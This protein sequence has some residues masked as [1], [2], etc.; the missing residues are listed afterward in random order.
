MSV[1]FRII[2]SAEINQAINEIYSTYGDEVS[3]A[4]KA[5]TLL[6]F[7]K[8]LDLDTGG[9]ETVWEVGGNEVYATGNTID[10]IS[11]SSATDT[12]TIV[13]EGHTVVGT[14]SDAQYSFNVQTATLNGQNKVVLSTPVARVSRAAN[15]SGTPLAGDVFI[16]EDT[17]IVSGVPSDL[18]KAHLKINGSGGENKSF[19]SATTFSN[20]DYFIMTSAVFSVGKATSASCDFQL[21]VRKPGQLFLPVHRVTVN[22][23]ASSTMQIIYSP[24]LIVPRNSD[25]RIRAISS[26]NNVEV[27]SSFAGYLANVA[28]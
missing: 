22:S 10:T 8:N 28:T 11:C 4:S 2:A 13:I 23:V 3:V 17:A 9:F 18:T 6:K 15:L 27:N 19:K 26:A 21:E 20:T 25:I 1:G 7:G 5:K 12:G 24:H 14:G 16:Y